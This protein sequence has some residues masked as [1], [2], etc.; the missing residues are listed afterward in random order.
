[1]ANGHSLITG[2]TGT[3]KTVTLQTLAEILAHETF[4]CSMADVKG[5]LAE[6]SQPAGI[7]RKSSGAQ[8]NLRLS[9]SKAKRALVVF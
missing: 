4:Q 7:I 3:G 5:D 2:A 9:I 6:L 8:R 1:M